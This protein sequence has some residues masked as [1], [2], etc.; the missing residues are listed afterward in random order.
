MPGKNRL[1]LVGPFDGQLQGKIKGMP[2]GLLAARLVCEEF[3]LKLVRLNQFDQLKEEI[4][5]CKATDYYH[6]VLPRDVPAI[7]HFSDL[8]LSCSRPIEGFGLPAL[9]ALACGLPSVL[10]DIPS[11]RDFDDADD[12][13]LWAP[14]G[15][16][17]Q[18]AKQLAKLWQDKDLQAHFRRR[19]PE[20][21]S[22]YEKNRSLNRLEAVLDNIVAEH[23]DRPAIVVRTY[24]ALSSPYYTQQ[25]RLCLKGFSDFLR[26]EDAPLLLNRKK[27]LTAGRTTAIGWQ[28]QIN[29]C[30][31]KRKHCTHGSSDYRLASRAQHEP[32]RGGRWGR[33][34]ILPME[35]NRLPFHTSI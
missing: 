29:T 27:Q 7:Y 16:S 31:G 28:A 6:G 13:A 4:P 14:P 9:E 23:Q 18:M 25:E 24:K 5:F 26:R 2:Q 17:V 15:D 8:F 1:L 30:G 35:R 10:S 12:F 32:K 3:G 11:H 34:Q 21:A 22:I 20:V 19:G 33:F